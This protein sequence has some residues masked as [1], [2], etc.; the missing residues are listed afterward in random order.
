MYFKTNL[1][2]NFVVGRYVGN[3]FQVSKTFGCT[4]A[5]SQAADDLV[6]FLNSNIL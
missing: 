6:R 4:Q 2:C 5:D 1:G 3:E